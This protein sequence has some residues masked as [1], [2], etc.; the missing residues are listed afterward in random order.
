MTQEKKKK[1]KL[2]IP[3]MC[4]VDPY[5]FGMNEF[6]AWKAGRDDDNVVSITETTEAG[7]RKLLSLEIETKISLRE[8]KVLPLSKFRKIFLS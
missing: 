2:R 1:P 6:E 4:P 3:W 7:K 5:F 8:E